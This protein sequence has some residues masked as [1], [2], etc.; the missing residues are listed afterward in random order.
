MRIVPRL[1]V[2][3]VLRAARALL[4]APLAIR[5]F[6]Y[7]PLPTE[8]VDAMSKCMTGGLPVSFAVVFFWELATLGICI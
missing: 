3:D 7:K 6:P 4:F 1:V 8:Y 5:A 2:F